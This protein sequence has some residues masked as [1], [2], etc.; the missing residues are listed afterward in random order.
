M[1]TQVL[2]KVGSGRLDPVSGGSCLA[3]IRRIARVS[4]RPAFLTTLFAGLV[5]TARIVYLVEKSQPDVWLTNQ[6]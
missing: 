6:K 4:Q 3:W 2:R 5:S 1:Q